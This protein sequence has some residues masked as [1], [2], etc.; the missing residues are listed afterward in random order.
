[1]TV[2]IKIP[3]SRLVSFLKRVITACVRHVTVWIRN[4]VMRHAL[5]TRITHRQ[6]F[7]QSLLRFETN[8]V[9]GEELISQKS[10]VENQ[11]NTLNHPFGIQQ[12]NKSPHISDLKNLLTALYFHSW[13]CLIFPTKLTILIMDQF[14]SKKA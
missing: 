4:E 3:G 5:C 11:G 1:M 2:P 10:F 8:L 14:Q 12:G 6:L 7:S 13:I 9:I